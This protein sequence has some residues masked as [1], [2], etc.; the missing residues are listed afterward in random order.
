MIA[1]IWRGQARADNAPRYEEHALQRL[2]PS[3]AA[4]PGHRGAY[5]LTRETQDEV[6]FLAVTLWD[7]VDS[8]RLP[9][10]RDNSRTLG[11]P[12]EYLL[13]CGYTALQRTCPRGSSSEPNTAGLRG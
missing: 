6:E 4:L 9:E 8:D 2:F 11:H 12:A 3:L 5:L 10:F 1:R 7:S 13:L